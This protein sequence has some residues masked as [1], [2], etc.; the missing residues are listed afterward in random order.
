MVETFQ[1]FAQCGRKDFLEGFKWPFSYR[2]FQNNSVLPESKQAPSPDKMRT[3]GS[4]GTTHYDP[5]RPP[6]P[7]SSTH[8]LSGIFSDQAHPRL[9]SRPSP[10]GLPLDSATSMQSPTTTTTTTAVEGG[11]LCVICSSG[12]LVYEKNS[13]RCWETPSSK[14][15]LTFLGPAAPPDAM[16]TPQMPSQCGCKRESGILGVAGFPLVPG[17]GEGDLWKETLSR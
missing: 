10:P 14:A 13:Y 7:W 12:Q 3:K 5:K 6:P 16:I 15:G 17:A 4:V 9:R 11:H 8:S 2:G 1:E